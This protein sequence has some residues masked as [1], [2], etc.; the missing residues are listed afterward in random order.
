MHLILHAYEPSFICRPC[1]FVLNCFGTCLQVSWRHFL[2]CKHKIILSLPCFGCDYVQNKALKIA[3]RFAKMCF[4]CFTYN[5]GLRCSLHSKCMITDSAWRRRDQDQHRMSSAA[6]RKS[7]DQ[8]S[9]QNIKRSSLS[10]LMATKLRKCK[11][12]PASCFRRVT[13]SRFSTNDRPRLDETP[14]SAAETDFALQ[15]RLMLSSLAE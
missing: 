8:Q 4:C 3:K 9:Q 11:S 6:R 13:R 12:D 1:L 7:E 15:R 10:W 5:Y 14:G 2:K